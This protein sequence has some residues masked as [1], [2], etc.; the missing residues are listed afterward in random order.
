MEFPL[1][2]TERRCFEVVAECYNE[3]RASP[4]A[5]SNSTTSNSLSN[6]SRKSSRTNVNSQ[7]SKL[8]SR[9]VFLKRIY[10]NVRHFLLNL[11]I[12]N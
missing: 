8:I 3:I 6:P 12:N 11:I 10:S 1:M 9:Y 7:T 5:T 4:S 2:L